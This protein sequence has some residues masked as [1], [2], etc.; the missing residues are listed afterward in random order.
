[1][2]GQILDLMIGVIER[3]GQQSRRVIVRRGVEG[4]G[5]LAAHPYELGQ[6]ELG[7]MLRY[8]VWDVTTPASVPGTERRDDREHRRAANRAIGLSAAGLALT[9]GIELALASLT[10]SVGLL[11][12]AIHNLSDVSTS[13]VVFLGFF[14]SRR[15]SSRRYPYGYERAEDLAGLGVAL[16]IWASAVFAGVESYHKL[17]THAPTTHLAWGMAGAALGIAGNQAVAWYKRRVGQRIHSTTLLAD[18]KHSWLDA[19][20]SGGALL[21]LIAVALGFPLGDP[22]AGFAITVF[23]AHVGYEVTRD[24][25]HHLMDGVEVEYLDRA[26]AAAGRAG[27]FDV[28]VVR[29]RWRGRSLV[30]ELESV[31]PPVMSL[32]D[33]EGRSAQM[34]DAVLD[35]VEEAYEVTVV[36]GQPPRRRE[37]RKSSGGAALRSEGGDRSG[38]GRIGS[39]KGRW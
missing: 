17:V 23:I 39:D 3:L 24:V 28:P 7:E 36:P 31:F 4:E 18:A 20:S 6:S 14:V 21:G 22:V 34:R 30:L 27:G 8:I 9:G 29:G 37:A 2:V 15:A 13:A 19:I 1:M 11:G 38:P 26:K 33:A 32:S 10:H 35:A 16:V 5:A 12:D 25:V